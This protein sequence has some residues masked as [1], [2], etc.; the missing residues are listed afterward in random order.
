MQVRVSV[1]DGAGENSADAPTSLTVRE[2]V[3]T[4]CSEAHA[5]IGEFDML[6]WGNPRE[7][8]RPAWNVRLCTII[9]M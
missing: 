8:F 9:A 4:A 1:C 7:T 6:P 3:C 5:V 2:Q